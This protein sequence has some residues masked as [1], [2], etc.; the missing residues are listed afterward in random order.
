MKLARYR[1]ASGRIAWGAERADGGYDRLAGPPHE[2]IVRSGERDSAADVR[3]LAP[4]ECP[5]IF[6][7]GLN[8]A[9]HAVEAGQPRPPSRCSS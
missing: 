8:Y 1:L 3:L 2:A 7:V 4:A 5:R 9:A 6:G